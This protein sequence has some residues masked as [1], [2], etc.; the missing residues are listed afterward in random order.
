MLL[1]LLGLVVAIGLFSAVGYTGY[2][3]GLAQG[4][5]RAADGEFLRLR[6][7]GDFGPRVPRM[8]DFEFRGG[9]SPRFIEFPGREFGLIGSLF[10]LLFWLAA[11][12]LVIGLVAWLFTRRGWRLVRETNASL[13][14][15]ANEPPKPENE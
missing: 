15:S 10:R 12:A 6:P 7:F 8:P 11:L 2:R 1:T 13:E 5:E 4:R 9:F 14:Q 3:L